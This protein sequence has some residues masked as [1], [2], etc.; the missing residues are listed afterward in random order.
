MYNK[1]LISTAVLAASTLI[2]SNAM[3]FDDDK[4]VLWIAPD[5]GIDGI[6]AIGE[7]FFNDLGIE[8]VIEHPEPLTDK[9]QQAAGTGDGPDIVFWP[10][11]RLGEWAASG[12]ISPVEPS[13]SVMDG[14]FDT[15][16]DAV[17]QN[18]KYWG[19]P[20]S[21]EAVGLIY[22][23]AYIDSAPRSF[24]DIVD[25]DLPDGVAPILWDYNNTY[26]TFPLM[27]ASGGYAFRKD[28][29]GN[30][31]PMDTGVNN[32]GA[33]AGAEMLRNLINVG[34]MPAGVDY[35]VMDAAMNKGEVAMVINGPWAWGQLKQSG[36]DFGVAPLPSIDGRPAAPFVGVYSAAINAATPNKDIA[37]EFLENYL[38]T[39]DGLAK[40]NAAS[41]IGAAA[42]KSFSEVVTADP[43]I[44]AT[45][46]NAQNGVPMPGIP[47]MGKFWSAMEPALQNITSGR[48]LPEA[49]LNDAAKRILAE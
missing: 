43:N 5:K 40:M 21:F 46:A 28:A 4:L 44:A 14:I 3:A 16:W 37:K 31:D 11:D 24:A 33:I 22:N 25:L 27:M 23:K 8:I 26:F 18:G 42:D 2:A 6:K 9:F 29:E 39:D 49:A 1:K 41:P 35:G 19:Y 7:Q 10:H 38:L 47:A 15:G 48:Q 12:L 17:S 45:L 13:R 34:V 36:I 20:I 32:A 30:Y